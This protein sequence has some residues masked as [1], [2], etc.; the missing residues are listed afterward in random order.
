[1]KYNNSGLSGTFFLGSGS[2][3]STRY[4]YFLKKNDDNSY[5]EDR[6][7]SDNGRVYEDADSINPPY[8]IRSYHYQVI[9]PTLKLFTFNTE[10]VSTYGGDCSCNKKPIEIHVPK[11]TI[12]QEYQIKL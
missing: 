3:E 1:M 9:S 11:G 8:V 7:R 10:G 2:I 5:T 6:V 12:I 4:Y